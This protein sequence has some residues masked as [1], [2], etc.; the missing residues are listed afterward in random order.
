[1]NSA[2]TSAKPRARPLFSGLSAMLLAG[3]LLAGCATGTNAPDS[4]SDSAPAATR[5]DAPR[6]AGNDI[7]TESDEPAARKR[8]RIRLALAIGY[9]EQGQTTIALDEVKQALAIDPEFADAYNMRG[10]VYMR[11][12][13]QQLAEDSFRRAVALKPRDGA[14]LHNQGWLYCEQRRYPQAAERFNQALANPN[15][16][17]RSRTLMAR[18]LCEERAGQTAEA[19]RSLTQSYE[20]DAGNPVTGYNLAR[21][22][23]ERGDFER[24]RF[25][26]RRLNNSE[27][28]NAES[29][30]LGVRVEHRMDNREAM[31]QLASQLQR[32]FPQA[33][34]LRAYE[35]GEF[36]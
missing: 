1:M 22:L 29:L 36:K 19:E 10:L 16:G 25:Y 30:W 31:L 14:I 5:S 18:G 6:N 17:N 34:E 32:R 15:Y 23:Y 4:D 26:I 28:A 7:V 21:L 8:A 13:D 35:R 27:L 3:A 33:P 24:S 2:V 20:L 9:L 11:L 12:N